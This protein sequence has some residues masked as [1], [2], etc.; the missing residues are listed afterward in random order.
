VNDCSISFERHIFMWSL[1]VTN[2]SENVI[3]AILI[4]ISFW[5]IILWWFISLQCE[6]YYRW[7]MH[8][9]LYYRIILIC[10]TVT[11]L[12]TWQMWIHILKYKCIIENWYYRCSFNL[13]VKCSICGSCKDNLCIIFIYMLSSKTLNIGWMLFT[14]LV[15]NMF[16]GTDTTAI[17]V[18]RMWNL[19]SL[20]HEKHMFVPYCMNMSSSTD[21]T[22][23]EIFIEIQICLCEL[24]RQLFI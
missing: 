14:N 21:S 7:T 11:Q 18:I 3:S 10:C 16:W 6:Y 23:C 8:T 2:N 15:M 20:A 13:N 17:L 12:S 9:W 22:T 5:D 4:P 19:I 1:L 24:I